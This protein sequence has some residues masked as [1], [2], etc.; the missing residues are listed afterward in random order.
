M[1]NAPSARW[2]KEFYR[3]ERE[4]LTRHHFEELFLH[5]PEIDLP[6]KGAIV[7]PH[8]RLSGSGELVAAV[9]SAVVRSGRD[10]VLALGVLHG[11]DRNN[12]ELRGIHGPGMR[13]DTEIWR[14]EFSLDN[15][16]VF[17]SLAAELVGKPQPHLIARYPFLTGDDP[18]GLNGFEELRQYV[19]NGA[20]LVATADMIHHGVGYGTPRE[21][22]KYSGDS[23]T[24]SWVKGSLETYLDLL[25]RHDYS[26][27]EEMSKRL[28]SDFRDAGPVLSALVEESVPPVVIEE[29]KLVNY[30][31]V[32]NADDPTWVAAALVQYGSSPQ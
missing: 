3:E 5:A 19:E 11:Q 21:E 14:D 23:N 20:A 15:F 18:H 6:E 7:F 17:L 22:C 24:H 8:T 9:A 28:R 30:A 26:A 4:S 2:W 10:T 31:D 27:F 29:L 13:H 32:L 1:S 25:V 16:E 12:P